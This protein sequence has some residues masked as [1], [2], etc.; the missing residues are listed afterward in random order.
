MPRREDHCNNDEGTAV[1]RNLVWLLAILSAA[2]RAQESN[3]KPARLEGKVLDAASHQP[4]KKAVVILRDTGS[5]EPG[6]S[7][8]LTGET[9]HFEFP[10][11]PPGNWS[12]Q[13]ERDG[14]VALGKPDD[15]KS[16]DLRWKLDAGSVVDDIIVRLT[17]AGVI[18]G[19]VVDADGGPVSGA[20]VTVSLPG[21]KKNSPPLP[22]AQTND[23][24]EYRLYN[25]APG[26]YIVT[27]TYQPSWRHMGV[28]LWKNSK[29]ADTQAP[30]EDYVTTYYPGTADLSQASTLSV[31]AGAHLSGMDIRLAMGEVVRVRGKVDGAPGPFTMLTLVELKRAAWMP[32]NTYNATAKLDGTFEFD[33]VRPGRYVLTCASGFDAVKLQGK[34]R[35]EVG[36]DDVDGIQIAL[37]AP[38]KIQGKVAVEGSTPLPIGLHAVLIPREDDPTHQAGGFS[39]VGADGLFAFD[40][41]SDDRYDLILAK[42]EGE[43]DNFYVKSI[44]FGDEDA[45]TGGVEVHGPPP[46]KL[47]VLLRDDGGTIICTVK[48]ANGEAVSH[49]KVTAV[50]EEPRRHALALYGEAEA[51]ESG[52]CKV[53]GL[54]PGRYFLLASESQEG[55]DAR[56]DETWQRLEKLGRKVEVAANQTTTVELKII[57]AAG[58]E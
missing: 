25:L 37:S 32:S 3:P 19:R 16:K 36:S 47:E 38:H 45:L 21:V 50:P 55:P 23:L 22:W 17:P 53:Q 4:V 27:A 56:Q 51:D 7:A 40:A 48:S 18:T 24:G 52:Q 20:S 54:A 6:G 28:R 42:L 34:Q 8:V 31:A 15:T 10:N 13:I 5:K 46:G 49:A 35:V 57:P 12:A 2:V 9:G 44:R 41:V 14:Y 58:S 39:P 11:L 29:H 43:P 1:L 26:K 30:R 33:N